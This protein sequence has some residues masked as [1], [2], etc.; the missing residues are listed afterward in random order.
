MTALQVITVETVLISVLNAFAETLLEVK[1]KK[2]TFWEMQ[3]D[4]SIQLQSH[5]CSESIKSIK[6]KKKKE[7]P[8][9]VVL[10]RLA[11]SISFRRVRNRVTNDPFAETVHS[12]QKMSQMLCRQLAFQSTAI[13]NLQLGGAITGLLLESRLAAL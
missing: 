12:Q 8:S 11:E 4:S 5:S 10:L 1:E 2:K 6:K 9:G 7:K 13:T 3:S